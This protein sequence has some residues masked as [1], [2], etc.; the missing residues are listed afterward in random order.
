MGRSGR[1]A[2]CPGAARLPDVLGGPHTKIS[3]HLLRSQTLEKELIAEEAAE[4][5]HPVPTDHPGLLKSTPAPCPEPLTQG[6]DPGKETK[7]GTETARGVGVLLDASTAGT[8]ET[9]KV[10]RALVRD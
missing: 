6:A 7:P 3:L 1:L 4:V 10:L 2:T 5:K 8:T 9:P